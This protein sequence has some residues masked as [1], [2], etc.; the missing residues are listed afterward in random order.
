MSPH[1]KELADIDKDTFDPT[2][3]VPAVRQ[4]QNQGIAAPESPIDG[5]RDSIKRGVGKKVQFY[6]GFF[7]QRRRILESP[8]IIVQQGGFRPDE[9]TALQFALRGLLIATLALQLVTAG[10]NF[11]LF[12]RTT[13]KDAFAIRTANYLDD[14]KTT[15]ADEEFLS[16][17]K[18]NREAHNEVDDAY[19]SQQ[20][21]N[22]KNREQTAHLELRKIQAQ[23]FILAVSKWLFPYAVSIQLLIIGL[24]F[25]RRLRKSRPRD[26]T[27]L[28]GAD[29]VL[30]YVYT[31]E[32]FW[33]NLL[34]GVVWTACSYAVNYN[35]IALNDLKPIGFI[36]SLPLLLW[37][38]YKQQ[39]VVRKLCTVFAALG[40]KVDAGFTSDVEAALRK[41]NKVATYLAYAVGS[42]SYWVL[43][44][45]N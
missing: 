28:K 24:A 23:G 42:V 10:A 39:I 12:G 31:A 6:R 4:D 26:A 34:M 20:T 25:R 36:I 37:S 11:L 43:S 2:T 32:A 27:V 18:S 19:I 40:L 22:L 13:L 30:L 7:A 1:K 5:L 44:S 38:L 35:F 14:L 16:Q 29:A 41:S 3:P 15:A 33:V 9:L 8:E 17:M 45:L 21:E